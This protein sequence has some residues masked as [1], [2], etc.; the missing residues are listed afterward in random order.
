L[1]GSHLRYPVATRQPNAWR[2][3]GMYLGQPY[4]KPALCKPHRGT[5]FLH[6]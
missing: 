5:S 4:Q 6:D 2:I 3:R 1:R